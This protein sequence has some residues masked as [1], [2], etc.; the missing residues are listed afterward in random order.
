MHKNTILFDFD[1]TLA[2]SSQGIY[3][4]I[5]YAL[6]NMNLEEHDFETIKN[7]IGHSL[8]E[9]FR[10]LT[11]RSSEDEASQFV[12]LF[13]KKADEIMNL[14]TRVYPEVFDLIPQLKKHGFKTGIISTKYR[15][16]I[17]GVLEREHLENYFDII[18]G[19][20]DVANHK[21]NPEGLLLAIKKLRVKNDEVWYV[22]DS[23][24]DAIAAKHASVDF[25]GVLTG[26]VKKT[27]FI[28]E[29]HHSIVKNLKELR[30][31]VI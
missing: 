12:K 7:T 20:E 31:V 17:Q 4:C 22:G 21:P 1:F 28:K 2:D 30:K 16:R 11:K 26:T 18:V 27:G 9:T 5:N 24:V 6:S 14:N 15:Y 25:I 8:P 3:Q 29:E 13:V 19:G 23:L 10:M